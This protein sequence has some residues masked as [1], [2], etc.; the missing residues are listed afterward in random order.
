METESHKRLLSLDVFRGLTIAGM[1]L[2]NSPGN[3]SAYWPLEHAEWNGMTPTDLVFPFFV[4][5]LGVSLVFS[6]RRRLEGGASRAELFGTILKRTLIIF[7]VGLL[8][9]GFPYYHLSSVRILGV[10]QR[11][12]LCYFFAAV[13]FLW[14]T[15][16]TQILALVA[17]LLGY[18]GFMTLY[19]VPGFGPGNLTKEGN[20]A[21][22][23]DRA[24]LAGHLYRPVYDPEG[25]LS[26][27]PAVATAISGT[28]T[29]IWLRYAK[30]EVR[31]V[32]GMLQA[33]L[34]CLLAG[35]KWGYFF[36]LNKALWTS[37]Y[38]L[39]S[40]GWALVLLS[41]CYWLIEIQGWKRWSKPFEVFG[42]NAIAAYFLHVF[43]LKLQNLWKVPGPDGN[44]IPVRIAFTNHVF[45]GWLSPQNASLGY[46]LSYTFLWLAVFWI[47]YHKK[48]F[49]KI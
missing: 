29:G 24:I 23:I 31:K 43:F 17:I 27:L 6:M 15:V 45:G 2:V 41:L 35:W 1:V 5:I 26:T 18:W 11:I 28:L 19:P 49:I 46:A 32:T 36:P 37:S 14:G 40:T 22:F 42:A 8:L 12:A 34:V 48:I 33:G 38:V 20:L 44:P 7:S 9:N 39:V 10:L 4:F 47:L 21:S 25:I 30:V 16:S 13:I 3:D